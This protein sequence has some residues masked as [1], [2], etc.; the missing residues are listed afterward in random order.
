MTASP[1]PAARWH[2]AEEDRAPQALLAAPPTQLLTSVEEMQRVFWEETDQGHG[3]LH[4]V[5]RLQLHVSWMGGRLSLARKRLV[6]HL[7][8]ACNAIP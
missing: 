8:A 1:A 6:G 7:A 5:P 2:Y 4:Q 3:M